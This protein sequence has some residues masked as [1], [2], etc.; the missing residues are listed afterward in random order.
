M[1]SS[2]SAKGEC[3]WGSRAARGVLAKGRVCERHGDLWEWDVQS[4]AI[5]QRTRSGGI[6]RWRGRQGPGQVWPWKPGWVIRIPP[7]A[8]LSQIR[9]SYTF[10]TCVVMQ[11]TI[12]WRLVTYL[13]GPVQLNYFIQV[14]QKLREFCYPILRTRKCRHKQSEW[15]P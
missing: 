4:T 13:Q 1:G 8:L 5:A 9:Y 2:C 14:S 10:F 7:G 6:W 3:K 11:H 15:F 12:Q